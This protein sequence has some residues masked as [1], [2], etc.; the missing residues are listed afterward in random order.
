[1]EFHVAEGFQFSYPRNED[2]LPVTGGREADMSSAIKIEGGLPLTGVLTA[3]FTSAP[4]TPPPDVL[5]NSDVLSVHCSWYISGVLVPYIG[6]TWHLRVDF[7]SVG[8]G[9]EFSSGVITVPLDGRSG[10]G[11]PYTKTIVIPAG[12]NFPA[13]AIPKVKS[14][15]ESTTYLV[16]AQLTYRDMNGQPGPMAAK[17]DLGKVTFYL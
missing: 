4:S 16:V 13:S 1:M 15:G 2:E 14:G 17:E 12:L 11:T 8:G 3:T 7:E 9:D 6:G 10:P 5:R